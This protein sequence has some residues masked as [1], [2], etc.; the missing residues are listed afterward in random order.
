MIFS[1]VLLNSSL[2][3]LVPFFNSPQN[4]FDSCSTN[5]ENVKTNINSIFNVGAETGIK[6]MIGV[7]ETLTDDEIH[8]HL[9]KYLKEKNLFNQ[10][11]TLLNDLVY[12]VNSSTKKILIKAHSSSEK[13]EGQFELSYSNIF[14]KITLTQLFSGLPKIESSLTT[15]SRKSLISAISNYF[16]KSTQYNIYKNVISYLTFSF[17]NNKVEI[18]L[19]SGAK[20]CGIVDEGSVLQIPYQ[21][22][23]PSSSTDISTIIPVNTSL[24][25]ASTASKTPWSTLPTYEEF[26]LKL[27]EQFGQNLQ[28]DALQINVEDAFN[29]WQTQYRLTIVPSKNSSYYT[30]S[31]CIMF[32]LKDTR[33][34]LNQVIKVGQDVANP[35]QVYRTK[36]ANAPKSGEN[37]II[38]IIAAANNID[39]GTLISDDFSFTYSSGAGETETIGNKF[40]LTI[41]VNNNS[42]YYKGSVTINC[43]YVQQ[44]AIFEVTCQELFGNQGS[45]NW[46][47]N[48]LSTIS[49]QKFAF[50][51]MNPY[52]N[53][54]GIAYSNVTMTNTNDPYLSIGYKV[55]YQ[56]V[57]YDVWGILGTNDIQKTN[58][59]TAEEDKGALALTTAGFSG[60]CKLYGKIGLPYTIQYFGKNSFRKQSGVTDFIWLK[61]PGQVYDDKELDFQS[62]FYSDGFYECSGVKRWSVPTR[63]QDIPAEWVGGA[64]ISMPTYFLSSKKYYPYAKSNGKNIANNYQFATLY[65]TENLLETY[66]QDATWKVK[67]TNILPIPHVSKIMAPQVIATSSST[68]QQIFT[69]W[70]TTS[71]QQASTTYA[72]LLAKIQDNDSIYKYVVDRT[73]K[74]I[75]IYIKDNHYYYGEFTANLV[76]N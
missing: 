16:D 67:A 29:I 25:C 24:D 63:I 41:T 60:T 12:T 75:T 33:V 36:N 52:N 53:Q 72:D 2:L 59:A 55:K 42:R 20:Y 9:Y 39:P 15:P 1:T 70:V 13:Y 58:L 10:Y 28:T 14:P 23:T 57:E 64:A 22:N 51:R 11:P 34:A 43:I 46:S 5:L 40:T 56:N 32:Y 26:C 48:Q 69:A 3:S 76:L 49:S 74:T 18:H 47:T 45:Y 50:E 65:V 37:K 19:Q 35:M 38:N 71:A 27:K 7:T 8:G 6:P 17:Q 21:V 62:S 68:D 73:N 30:G 44:P 31:T 54:V 66:K 61:K 4:K